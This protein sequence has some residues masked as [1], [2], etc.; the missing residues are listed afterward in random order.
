MLKHGEAFDLLFTDIIMP[1][2]MNG[3]ELGEAA[4]QLAPQI[5]ILYTSGYP[6]AAFEHLGLKEQSSINFL[7]KPYKAEDLQ[8]MLA[9][10]FDD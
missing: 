8:R 9:E 7:S 1:G 4:L 2:G 6:A 5:K 3:Q 10:I